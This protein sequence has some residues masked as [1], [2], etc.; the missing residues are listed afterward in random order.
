MLSELDSRNLLISSYILGFPCLP[1][2]A[3][4]ARLPVSLLP[5]SVVLCVSLCISLMTSHKCLSPA[6][7][8]SLSLRPPTQLFIRYFQKLFKPSC[9]SCTHSPQGGE[10]TTASTPLSHRRP[11]T[12]PGDLS[13]LTALV[14]H[15]IPSV[16]PSV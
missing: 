2:I 4:P 3:T 10:P 5:L 9:S 16:S 14:K 11:G 7:V 15:E 6:E 1:P 13:Y 8:F 12:Q